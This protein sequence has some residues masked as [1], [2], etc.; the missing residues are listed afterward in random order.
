MSSPGT[1]GVPCLLYKR[2]PNVLRWLQNILR[3][4]WNNLMIGE[5][6]MKAKAVYILKEQNS[7]E[8]NLLNVEGKIFFSDMAS[9][10]TKYLTENGC[11][12]VS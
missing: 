10:L 3:S 11:V 6:Y 12:N 7:N 1:K 5:Q 8:I 4:T 2:C 9:H